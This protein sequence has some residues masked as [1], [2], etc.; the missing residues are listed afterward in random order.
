MPG[1]WKAIGGHF[2]HN[3]R[4]EMGEQV[5]TEEGHHELTFNLELCH[6]TYLFPSQPNS[7]KW[8]RAGSLWENGVL[9]IVVDVEEAP[10]TLKWFNVY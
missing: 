7:S 9:T 4:V 1:F 5:F 3:D 6:K 10:C 2:H 8:N